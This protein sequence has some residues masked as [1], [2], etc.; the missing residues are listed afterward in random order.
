MRYEFNLPDI[1]EGL[2]EAVVRNWLVKVGDTVREDDPVCEVETDKAVVEITSPCDGAIL[3]LN[4]E[5]GET[6]P[7]GTVLIVFETESAP[8]MPSHH[9]ASAPAPAKD[10]AAAPIPVKE[11][12]V[13]VEHNQSLLV[14]TSN[15]NVLAVPSTR[16]YAREHGIDLS[17]LVGSGPDGRILHSD[18]L[19]SQVPASTPHA[20][21][22]VRSMAQ[23]VTPTAIPHAPGQ[24]RIP[25]KGLRRAIAETMVRS[26]T[27]IP[28]ATSMFRCN[29]E[30]F[31]VL[32]K[33]LQEKLGVR[34]SFTAMVIKA[35]VPALQRYPYFNCSIDD[36]SNEIVLPGQINVGFATHTDEGLIVPVIKGVDRKSL[37][38]ISQD[39]DRLAA[40]ARERK[41]AAEDLRGGTITLSNVGSHGTAETTGGRPIINHPQSAVIV[42]SRIKPQPVVRDGQ[43]VAQ[44][45]LDIGTSYDH[46]VIDGIYAALFMETLINVIEEPGLLLGL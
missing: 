39:I 41:I 25:I 13:A 29:G 43:V 32:R 1:G 14:L 27:I 21:G 17:K 37:V 46:R 6:H 40:L 24:E 3:A 31:L 12:V 34:V 35:M 18:V 44:Q 11:A 10:G 4:G 8:D 2:T 19:R 16:R 26:V 38:E 33:S 23:L 45:C 28:H 15:A 20:G 22:N 42:M 9:G 7:V 5:A 30:R 36:T